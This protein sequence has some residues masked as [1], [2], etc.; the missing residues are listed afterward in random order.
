MAEIIPAI[1][2]AD[3]DELRRQL[4]R[5]GRFAPMVHIDIVDGVLAPM[6]TIGISD[7]ELIRP[8]MP[9]ELHVMIAEPA[10]ALDGLLAYGPM[11]VIVHTHPG[12][13]AEQ[14]MRR[15]ALAGAEPALGLAER[16]L[17][18]IQWHDW[19]QL[20]QMAHQVTFVA[21]EPGYQG[22]RLV[23]SVVDYAAAFRDL[24]PGTPIELDG[25]VHAETLAS[26]H[27]RVHAH[28]YVVG[29]AFLHAPKPGRLYKELLR[30]VQ[31]SP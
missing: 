25:G 1:L 15:I 12:P 10:H 26:L 9:F 27:E 5:Y 19:T 2:T 29:S 16:Q 30:M 18:A 20:L 14:M 31:S 21:A 22:G 13:Q 17:A 6:R 3:P 23:A 28:R 7:L 4:R 11:R 8:T 24:H